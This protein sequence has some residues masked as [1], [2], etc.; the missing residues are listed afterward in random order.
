MSARW[1]IALF[2]GLPALVLIVLALVVRQGGDLLPAPDERVV[3]RVPSP[4]G[5]RTAVVAEIEGD[6]TV[7]FG[8]VVRV[9]GEEA[10]MAHQ[11]V[12]ADGRE[13]LDVRWLDAGTLEVAFA[14]ARFT[15][16]GRVD[17]LKVVVKG[18]V[19]P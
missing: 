17:G 2:V 15:R 3:A 4:S 6:A 11:P 5:R 19:D 9:D 10:A 8:T 12:R 7:G 1:G 18:A 16:A 13:G 14:H